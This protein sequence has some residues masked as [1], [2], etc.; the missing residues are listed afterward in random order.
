MTK[1]T[2]QQQFAKNAV[3]WLQLM[4]SNCYFFEKFMLVCSVVEE[5]VSP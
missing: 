5:T 2:M 1:K 4:L 3:A